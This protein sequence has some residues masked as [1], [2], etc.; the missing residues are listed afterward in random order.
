MSPHSD[1]NRGRSLPG[2]SSWDGQT[3]TPS[4]GKEG[5]DHFSEGTPEGP[6]WAVP[7]YGVVSVYPNGVFVKPGVTTLKGLSLASGNL[8][9]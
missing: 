3:A 7:G 6:G 1:N 9:L 4:G 8:A 2:R 5:V